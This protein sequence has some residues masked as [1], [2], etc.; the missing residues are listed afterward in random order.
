MNVIC[1]IGDVVRSR[2]V[3]DRAALQRTFKGAL[4]AIN[5]L[6]AESLLSPATITLGDEFQ[7]VYRDATDVWA[8]F[9]SLLVELHP[10]GMRFAVG[11]G[12]LDTPLNRKQ[13][14]GMDG[15][16]FH[17]ARGVMAGHLKS[18]GHRFGWA[19]A[20]GATPAWVVAG[21]DLVSVQVN[22]WKVSRH[23]VCRRYLQGVP[24]REIAAE[25]G[26]TPAAVYKNIAEGGLEPLARLLREVSGW[27]NGQV[28]S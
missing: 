16:A 12:P 24:V 10:H 1:V 25:L 20:G 5:G 21:L 13:A 23:R 28:A 2:D 7:A 27:A 14:I 9:W 4:K 3:E 26:L 8:D 18:G 19:T 17:V 22:A 6:R 15:P 11:I